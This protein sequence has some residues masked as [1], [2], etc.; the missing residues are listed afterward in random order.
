MISI[1][2]LIIFLNRD[3][4][5]VEIKN[6]EQLRIVLKGEETIT[7]YLGDEYVEYGYEAYEF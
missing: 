3:I 6:A 7:L 4:E 1:T 2:L 5:D